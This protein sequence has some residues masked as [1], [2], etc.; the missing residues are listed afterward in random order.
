MRK[1]TDTEMTK[2]MTRVSE[3]EASYIQGQH[4]LSSDIATHRGFVLTDRKIF[5]DKAGDT[6][7]LRDE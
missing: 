3:L 4:A 5:I 2:L 1:E 7:V 6:L